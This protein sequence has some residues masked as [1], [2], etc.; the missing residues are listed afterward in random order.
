M[1]TPLILEDENGVRYKKKY[2]NILTSNF[3]ILNVIDKELYIQ[4]KINE[5]FTNL[6]LIEYNGTRGKLLVEDEFGFKYRPNCYDLTHGSKV[7]I[8]TCTE[9]EKLFIF[10]SNIKHNNFYIYNDFVYK[11][12]KT[13]ITITCPIHGDFKQI[14]ESHLQ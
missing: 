9:K 12:G 4:N 7:S 11:N 8:L 6:K 1:K 10:K 2:Q 3:N 5:K 14:G 13:K